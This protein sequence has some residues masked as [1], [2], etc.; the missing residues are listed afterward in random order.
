MELDLDGDGAGDTVTLEEISPDHSEDPDRGILVV[1][2]ANGSTDRLGSPDG[3]LIT[4]RFYGSDGKS[5][6]TGGFGCFVWEIRKSDKGRL[7]AA[8]M[9]AATRPAS[10]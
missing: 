3:P 8:V 4:R 2:F 1:D 7:T 10:H 6:H 9:R 5:R